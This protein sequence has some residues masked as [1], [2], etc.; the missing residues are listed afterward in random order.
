[1]SA[2]FVQPAMVGR[3]C[4]RTDTKIVLFLI[5][6]PAASQDAFGYNYECG[7]KRWQ[8]RRNQ[9]RVIE[10]MLSKYGGREKESIHL[11]PVYV[12]LDTVHNYPQWK[13]AVNARNPEKITRLGNGWHP[14]DEGYGQ[15]ADS[16]YFWLKGVLKE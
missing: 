14:S 5:P 2:V 1:M 10:R 16:L 8:S 9:R 4:V 15:I 6:P 11:V 13:P 3:V 12:N 7:L